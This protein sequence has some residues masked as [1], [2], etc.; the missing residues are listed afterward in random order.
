MGW[1]ADDGELDLDKKG[2]SAWP[3]KE[4]A[5]V[6]PENIRTLLLRKNKITSIPGHEL[7]QLVNL[8]I[9]DLSDN[10]LTSLPSEIGHLLNLEELYISGNELED[11]PV[12]LGSLTSL[13]MFDALPNPLTGLPAEAR[14]T[15]RAIAEHLRKAAAERGIGPLISV[16]SDAKQNN[17]WGGSHVQCAVLR[18]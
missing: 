15:D 10:K 16:A 8:R 5:K 12:E 1:E 13:H 2:I 17:T 7:A 14:A 4:I 9:L 3:S 18:L 11:L 6:G